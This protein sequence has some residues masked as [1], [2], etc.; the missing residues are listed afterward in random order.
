M[1]SDMYKVIV[2]RPRRGMRL[3]KRFSRPGVDF[4]SL[5]FRSGIGRTFEGLTGTKAL[6]ENLAPLERY[7]VRQVG[8]RWDDVFSE[9]CEN[10]DVGSSVKQHVRDHI[11]DLIL[12]KA[13]RDGDGIIRNV[14]RW[15]KP[16]NYWFQKVFVD[17]ST[18]IVRRS[19][20]LRSWREAKK[21][22][23][24]W[25]GC[26]RRAR[27]ETRPDLR[28]IDPDTEFR[29][30]RGIWYRIQYGIADGKE[31]RK[32][33]T[34]VGE[35]AAHDRPM[36]YDQLK[37]TLVSPRGRYAKSKRQLSSAELRKHDLVNN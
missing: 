17:P 18:G 6:N 37:R 16:E 13:N 20:S 1:R 30:L 35:G 33:G 26:G 29:K 10:L 14:S 24:N 27:K 2:E 8:R 4:E 23:S 9:I 36:V 11:E 34:E 31:L 19:D 32:A 12:I 22:Y 7:L 21:S 3:R 25:F 15:S 28:V 5:P